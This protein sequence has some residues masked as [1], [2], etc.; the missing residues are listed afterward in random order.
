MLK[1]K[2]GL[3]MKKV[4]TNMKKNIINKNKIIFKRYKMMMKMMTF[5]MDKNR[6]WNK[7]RYLLRK[8]RGK[9]I[10]ERNIRLIIGRMMIMKS[11][12]KMKMDF[13]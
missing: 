1:M 7:D 12:N 8:R 5:N 3:N 6:D 2:K 9:R 10:K 11:N 4:I 13:I